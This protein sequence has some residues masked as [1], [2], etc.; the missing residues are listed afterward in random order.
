MIGINAK[1]HIQCQKC[2]CEFESVV[3][4][5]SLYICPKCNDYACCECNYGFGSITPCKILV[6]DKTVGKIIKSGQVYKIVS[7]KLRFNQKLERGYKDLEVYKEAEGII[8]E[9]L[10]R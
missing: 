3:G 6:G 7:L 10:S 4:N 2:Y 9:H 8:K 5:N 1:K